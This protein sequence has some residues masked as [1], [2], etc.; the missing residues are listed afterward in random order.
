MSLCIRQLEEKL[1]KKQREINELNNQI[2][3]M[4][5]FIREVEW[6]GK[7]ELQEFLVALTIG[8]NR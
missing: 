1:N 4:V 3:R 6:R 5:V 2:E 8:A 7:E